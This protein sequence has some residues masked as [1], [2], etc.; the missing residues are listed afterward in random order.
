MEYE[1]MG[2]KINFICSHTDSLTGTKKPAIWLFPDQSYTKWESVPVVKTNRIP[3]IVNIFNSFIL[4]PL[5]RFGAHI[6]QYLSFG[7]RIPGLDVCF[8]IHIL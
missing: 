7:I 4:I 5:A 2:K 1:S 6:N 8:R 3:E